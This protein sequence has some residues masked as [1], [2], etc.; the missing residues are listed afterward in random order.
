MNIVFVFQDDDPSGMSKKLK[1]L[2]I[3]KKK[4]KRDELFLSVNDNWKSIKV[5]GTLTYI[6]EVSIHGGKL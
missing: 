6:Q 1:T 4:S 3:E 2:T 5:R